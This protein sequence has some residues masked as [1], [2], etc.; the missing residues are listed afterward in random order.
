M[1][2]PLYR[3]VI[4]WLLLL[5]AFTTTAQIIVIE[6]Y[7]TADIVNQDPWRFR[8]G[9]S[10]DWASPAYNNRHWEKMNP[11]VSLIENKALWKTG[12]GW[13]RKTIRFR[14]PNKDS[15]TLTVQQFGTST[16]YLD[17]RLLATLRPFKFDSGGSQRL[18]EF[19]PL[20]IT[21]TNQHVLAVRY[22]FRRD[23]LIGNTVRKIPLEIRFQPRDRAAVE[24]LRNQNR[25]AALE[26]VVVGIFG[27]LSLLHFLFYRANP[28][29]R[30]NLILSLT[31]LAFL[32]IFL[33]D[34]VNSDTGTLT[35]DSVMLSVSSVFVN[36][37]L[38]L[39]LLSVYTYLGRRL[40]RVFW[41]II[42]LLTAIVIY[43]IF[44]S[45][46]PE[47]SGGMQFLIVLIEYSRVSWLAKRRNPDPDAR[48]PWNSL[49]FS[50]Y[51]ILAIAVLGVSGSLLTNFSDITPAADWFTIPIVLLG[52]VALFSVP[53][54]LSFSLVS[55]YARTYQALRQQFD[56]VSRLSAQ[57]LAQ[58][59]EKQL[60]LATQNERLEQQVAD[61]TA[62]LSQSLT[63]LRETQT[64]LIQREKLASLGELTAGIAHEIQNPLNFV[65][66]F[67]EVSSELVAE[68]TEEADNPT[69]DRELEA[70]LLADLRQN[71]GKITHHGQRA[72][73]IVKGM[74][75]HSRSITGE[76]HPTDLNALAEE[77]LKLAYHAIRTKTPGFEAHI[78]MD[79]S[80]DL[81]LISIVSQE[82]GRVL[83]NL[84]S[85][86]FYAL[87]KRQ[88]T[89]ESGYKPTLWISTKRTATSIELHVRDNGTGIPKEARP[90][91]FQ[92]FFTTKPSGEGTGLG[93]SLSYDIITKGY[94]GTVALET[95]E[96]SFTEFTII[97]PTTGPSMVL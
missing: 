94:G 79:L 63:E 73:S 46:L 67:S 74:L 25:S 20:R 23:P 58:E 81:G 69:R 72:S 66:N 19:V 92:P 5:S 86:A 93:L 15:L 9:D 65:N 60:L 28:T 31:M 16:L 38:G 54:G 55:D 91:V 24:L 33:I 85:N 29:Q 1:I 78:H 30:V 70:E 97:L 76:R 48:L 34:Q 6:N 68:L 42:A 11:H 75:E 87:H 26:Y 18:V 3:L 62:E 95:E 39:L 45:S 64:Q 96:G 44:I 77:Y 49:K 80:A 53:I 32:L 12:R 27:V 57:T 7:S 84:F 50:L 8:A 22:A 2:R 13:F 4:G 71:L 82:I 52:L 40:G 61:R 17:G 37:A 21:D 14:K 41:G 10:L 47:G 51:T 56:T 89:T 83:L 90:K 88:Q 43:N 59:Q 36:L 35:L